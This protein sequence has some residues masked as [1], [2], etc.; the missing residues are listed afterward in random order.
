MSGE[1]RLFNGY[2]LN[3]IAGNK[4]ARGNA[5][6]LC[7]EIITRRGYRH[8]DATIQ[9]TAD[10]DDLWSSVNVKIEQSWRRFYGKTAGAFYCWVRKV[11]NSVRRNLEDQYVPKRERDPEEERRKDDAAVEFLL[12]S[13]ASDEPTPDQVAEALERDYLVQRALTML[14]IEDRAVVQMSMDGM[15]HEEIAEALGENRG[16]VR[17]AWRSARNRLRGDLRACA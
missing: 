4:E 12:E 13:L 17:C 8:L 6:L 9:A 5:V 7:R 15:T 16:A 14:P 3:A 10:D 11:L 1:W 2:V